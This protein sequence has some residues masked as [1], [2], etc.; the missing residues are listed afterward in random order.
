VDEQFMP[1]EDELDELSVPIGNIL[2]RRID[3]VGRLH[4]D[5]DDTV[6]LMLASMLYLSRIGPIAIDRT[7]N[8]LAERQ[9][10]ERVE[11]A[12]PTPTFNRPPEH[13]NVGNNGAGGV[14][15]GQGVEE[16]ADLGSHSHATNAIAR[17]RAIGLGTVGA[18][19]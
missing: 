4:D 16:R 9:L 11:P 18:T 17:A 3:L 12:G 19:T 15:H 7:R 13:S 1:T 14:V 5:A 2:A 6:A 8:A 10:R